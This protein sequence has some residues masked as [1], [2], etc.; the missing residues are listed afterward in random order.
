[1]SHGHIDQIV[2]SLNKEVFAAAY[3]V[4]LEPYN[5]K[6]PEYVKEKAVADVVTWLRSLGSNLNEF[7]T[8]ATEGLRVELRRIA[9][10]VNPS[11]RQKKD[12]VE[13]AV[14]AFISSLIGT[15][16]HYKS[17]DGIEREYM[18]KFC[19]AVVKA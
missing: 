10:S 12:K 17:I 19:K 16:R 1:M 4:V 18:Q 13:K 11:L 8:R 7:R 14:F 3:P 9:F 5:P 15:F 6:I 2:S